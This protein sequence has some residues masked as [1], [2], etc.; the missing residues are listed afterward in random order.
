MKAAVAEKRVD[1][2][3][4]LKDIR[5]PCLMLAGDQDGL[6]DK[7]R[8]SSKLSERVEFAAMPGADHGGSLYRSDI[9]IPQVLR[10]I[11]NMHRRND[12]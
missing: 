5:V 2:T 8:E 6:F 1:N 3:D 9:V 12:E 4:L 10:F 7:A 11:K